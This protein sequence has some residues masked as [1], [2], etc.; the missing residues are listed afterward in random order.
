MK[1]FFNIMENTYCLLDFKNKIH[2]LFNFKFAQIQIS[3]NLIFI[4]PVN[5]MSCSTTQYDCL[6]ATV[7]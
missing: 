3:S 5:Y 2:N 4:H 1:A 7:L 6:S